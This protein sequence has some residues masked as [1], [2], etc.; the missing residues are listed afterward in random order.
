LIRIT[1]LVTRFILFVLISAGIS[2]A[3]LFLPVTYQNLD[4]KLR[5]FMF[6]AR[7]VTPASDDI[8]IVDIDEKSLHTLGQWPWE[9]NVVAQMVQNLSNAGAGIIG[10]DIVFSEADKSSPHRF[11]QK[12]HI[13]QTLPNYDLQ[14]AKTISST[15]TILGYIFNFDP[16]FNSDRS[17]LPTIPAIF[18]E[19]NLPKTNYL[20]TPIG[21]LS[22]LKD[23]QESGYSSGY[24]NN[25]PDASGSIRSVPL[26]MRYQDSIYPSLAFEMF[27]I[28]NNAK[29]V[30]INYSPTGVSTIH[31]GEIDIPTDRNGRMYLNHRGPAKTFHYL[32]ASDIVNNTFDPKAVE[33]KFV[34]VG[35]S[36]YGLM[37]LRSNPFDNIIPG[38]EIQATVIDNLIK[39]DMLLRPD[40]IEIAEIGMIV[41]LSALVIFGLSLLPPLWLFGGFGIL[42]VGIGYLNYY[43]LFKYHIIFNLFF[44]VSVLTVS[45]VSVLS[46]NFFFENK[47]K[48][49]VKKKFAQKVSKQVMD[50]LLGSEHYNAL[51]TRDVEVTIFFSDIRSFTTISEQLGSP[52]RV[53]EFLNEYMTVMAEPIVQTHG[54]IDKFIGDAIMAYWNA[55][56]H[57]DN[58]ADVAVQT[59]LK[60]LSLRESL[61]RKFQTQFGI[62]LDFGIGLNTGIVTVGDIGSQGRSDYTVI[63]DPVNLASRLEGLCKYYHVRLI[64]SE[65]T[66]KA[67]RSPYVIREL[68]I[69]RV[70]GKT[71]PIRI[72]EVIDNGTAS[73]TL[74]E[75]LEDFEAALTLYRD[76]KFKEAIALFTLLENQ[77]PHLLYSLYSE[78]CTHLLEVGI[79][80]FDGVYEFHE[81]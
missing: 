30:T 66:Y 53:V 64:I 29:K 38:I 19:K 24:L 55:P 61:S 44:M 39:H 54:T 15:P 23:I 75:E 80:S 45:I 18:I 41:S 46:I 16:S 57:V 4:D 40:W 76:S 28:A 21:I 65:F 79:E 5:D 72:Y 9:R 14:F 47:Q 77:S 22:N 34:L 50:D 58:H 42:F 81:K 7:G 49:K 13:P 59:A 25:V 56:N 36:A 51:Q 63:G 3:Y 2:Y 70:K 20:L 17:I 10:L 27:R 52:E 26:I 78:R 6:L 62:N 31:A 33:G 68:D 74:Q 1:P 60:Q 48:E 32:S 37:D 8:V 73:E 43:L 35:T 69:V 71:E 11:A 67:L 12:F